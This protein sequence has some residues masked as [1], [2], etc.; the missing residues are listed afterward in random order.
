VQ[1]VRLAGGAPAQALTDEHR[2]VFLDALS[3]MADR[4]VP[5][6]AVDESAEGADEDSTDDAAESDAAE[7]TY[8]GLLRALRA[9][10][11]RALGG[12]LAAELEAQ[13]CAGDRA[14][15]FARALAAAA[16][17]DA[18]AKT[19]AETAAVDADQGEEDDE[20]EEEDEEAVALRK[21]REAVLAKRVELAKTHEKYEQ[22]LLRAI[23][24]DDA[25]L[26]QRDADP[27]WIQVKEMHGIE[28]HSFVEAAAAT[29]VADD[30]YAEYLE[31]EDERDRGEWAWQ[32]AGPLKRY[33]DGNA[34]LGRGFE[35]AERVMRGDHIA[36]AVK[37]HEASKRA[38]RG[39]R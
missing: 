37:A 2:K 1:C 32:S 25:A 11:S 34:L 24:E 4:L 7:M 28:D 35:H 8:P 19:E 36:E 38:A 21:K 39:K 29:P 10:R 22:G 12:E 15:A 18:T 20:D 16:E 17:A 3:A 13:V 33:T 6:E 23:D 31:P 30:E 9:K 27:R 26:A 14:E 5:D